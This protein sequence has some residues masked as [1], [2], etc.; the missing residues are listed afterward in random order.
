MSPL[1]LVYVGYL[2]PHKGLDTAI[3]AVKI[4]LDRGVDCRF[5]IV[6]P[7]EGIVYSQLSRLVR[8]KSL[9]Q[10]VEFTGRVT[11]G[12]DLYTILDEADVMLLPSRWDWQTRALFEG[13]ARGLPIVASR[14]IKSLPMMFR[15]KEDIYFV[16][17]DSPEQI[18]DAVMDIRSDR[19][20][21]IRL[22]NNALQIASTK[23]LE[24][25]A[26]LL[27]QGLK[28]FYGGGEGPSLNPHELKD[29][30]QC[31]E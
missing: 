17:P 16:D 27:L 9:G 7:K 30:L 10:A 6:G 4:L 15:H 18:A 11:H 20:L 25:S 12:P 2:R 8:E 28:G 3:A 29:G 24:K 19:A 23:T 26:E 1:R 22:I 14:G 5:Q 13:M 21:R 31:V